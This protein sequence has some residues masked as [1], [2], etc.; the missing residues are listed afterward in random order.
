MASSSGDAFFSVEEPALKAR[1]RGERQVA[2]ADRYVQQDAPDK[3]TSETFTYVGF[4]AYSLDPE[5]E[6]SPQAL[7]ED[8]IAA[9]NRT[10]ARIR[11]G[12]I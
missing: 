9:V 7:A 5:K 6:K 8:I 3:G 4:D 1:K 2:G 10:I 11:A 12:T